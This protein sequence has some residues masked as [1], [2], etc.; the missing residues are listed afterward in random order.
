MTR[1][2]YNDVLRANNPGERYPEGYLFASDHHKKLHD[3]GRRGAAAQ[4]YGGQA[5]VM[6]PFLVVSMIMLVLVAVGSV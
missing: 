5:I 3:E 2:E 6:I 1:K 4:A